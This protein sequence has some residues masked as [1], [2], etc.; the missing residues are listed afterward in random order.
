MQS[1]ATTVARY[2]D[3][4]P[5]DRRKIVET[6]RKIIRANIDKDVEEGMQY[7]MISY[8]IPHRVFPRGYHAD[9]KQPLPYIGLASQKNHLALYMG[10]WYNDGA[11][12]KLLRAGFAKAGKKVDL[13]KSCLRF[14]KLDDL[15]LDVIT[16]AV[17]LMGSTEYVQLYLASVG[18]DAWKGK[19]LPNG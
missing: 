6:L 19:K 7:G 13:G 4:L 2:L 15:D 10:F 14:R 1:K 8:Y 16:A 9:P 5:D 17:R 11:M 18:P 3:E 12:E